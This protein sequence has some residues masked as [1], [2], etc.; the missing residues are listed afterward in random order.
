MAR[1]AD[2]LAP[3]TVTTTSALGVDADWME[4]IAFAW[5]ARCFDKRE[6]ANLPAV[7][8]ARGARILGALYPA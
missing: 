4:A 7:T 2:L 8:G 5:L 3:A 6:T 1:L